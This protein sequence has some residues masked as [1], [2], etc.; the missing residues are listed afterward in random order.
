MRVAVFF[1]SIAAH[2]SQKPLLAAWVVEGANAGARALFAREGDGVSEVCRDA[3]FPPIC[4]GAIIE[5]PHKEGLI[6][7]EGARFFLEPLARGRRLVICGAGHVSMP[8]IKMGVMLDFEVTVIDDRAAFA[9]RAR[10]AGAHRVICKPFEEALRGIEGD[11]TTAFIIMTRE[12]AYDVDCLRHILRKPCAYAGMMGSRSRTAQI[13]QRMLE[14]GFDAETVQAVHMPIGMPI[15][16][17]TP[18]E[19]AVSVMAEIVQVM[20]AADAGEGFPPGMLETLI[21]LES[22]DAPAAVLAMIVEKLGEAPRR[23]GTKML[24]KSDGRFLGTVGGG[25]AEAMILKS[26]GNMLRAGCREPRLER[27]VLEKGTMYCGGEIAVF[28]LPV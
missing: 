18:A 25:T 4:A 17:R 6:E 2:K 11:E 27:I 12:H 21:A 15:G 14:E 5:N 3:A 28:M 19:I 13:R 10:D 20:N 23:P 8:V 26:A 9:D 22:G 16:S 1:E 24:V 7:V